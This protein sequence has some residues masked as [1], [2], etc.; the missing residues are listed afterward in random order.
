MFCLGCFKIVSHVWR[1]IRLGFNCV[2]HI[3]V[4]YLICLSLRF[5]ELVRY[6][7]RVVE[8]VWNCV[9]LIWVCWDGLDWIEMYWLC[10]EMCWAVLKLHDGVWYIL[11]LFELVWDVSSCVW[12]VLSCVEICYMNLWLVDMCVSVL[13][14][15]GSCCFVC[16]EVVGD[17]MRLFVTFGLFWVLLRLCEMFD[18]WLSCLVVSC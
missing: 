8:F 3:W 14:L 13:R 1:C 12:D 2:L 4:C 11:S 18:M 16:F 17:V 9:G 5:V 6:V 7:L 10:F 15:V